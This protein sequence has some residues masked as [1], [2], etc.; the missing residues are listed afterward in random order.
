MWP[1]VHG[2]MHK[3]LALPQAVAMPCCGLPVALHSVLRLHPAA[4]ASTAMAQHAK[5]VHGA[6]RMSGS[7]GLGVSCTA[8]AGLIGALRKQARC[9]EPPGCRACRALGP[10]LKHSL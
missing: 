4:G 5:V 8:T 9:A 3:N 1:A 6:W 2:N 7:A 10:T